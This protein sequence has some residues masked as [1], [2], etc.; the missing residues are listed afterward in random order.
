M[1]FLRNFLTRL[2]RSTFDDLYEDV[3][4]IPLCLVNPPLIVGAG[5]MHPDI[6]T[7]R[8]RLARRMLEIDHEMALNDEAIRQA[9]RD[10]MP[11]D[12][13]PRAHAQI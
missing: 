5:A 13:Q 3:Q 2:T 6:E 4:V 11:A 7:M 8:E 12:S 1:A 9:V 10:A